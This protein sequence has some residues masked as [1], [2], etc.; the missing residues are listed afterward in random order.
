MSALFDAALVGVGGGAFAHFTAAALRS[1]GLSSLEL[2]DTMGDVS[3]RDVSSGEFVLAGGWA[4]QA[5]M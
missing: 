1:K 4:A 5:A 3:S 2:D